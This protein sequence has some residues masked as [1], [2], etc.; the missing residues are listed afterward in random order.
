MALEN[1]KT[2]GFERVIRS[3]RRKFDLRS[4]KTSD[5][6]HMSVTL[7]YEDLIT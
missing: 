4:R 1:R 3:F 2:I 7:G 6:V 5:E